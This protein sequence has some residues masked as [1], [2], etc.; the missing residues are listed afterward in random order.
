LFDN[1]DLLSLMMI[2]CRIVS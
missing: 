2:H 1:I